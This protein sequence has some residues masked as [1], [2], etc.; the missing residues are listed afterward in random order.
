MIARAHADII[1]TIRRP[2]IEK[3]MVEQGADP[4][5]NTPQ[6]FAAYLGSETNR[7]SLS[8]RASGATID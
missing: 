3:H 5:G 7:W 6:E 8:I 1:A 2:D 4:M